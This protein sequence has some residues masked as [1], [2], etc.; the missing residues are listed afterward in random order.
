MSLRINIDVNTNPAERRLSAM[1]RRMSSFKSVFR[2]VFKELQ[3]AHRANFA[4]QGA[5]GGDIWKPLDPQYASWKLENYGARGI[6][7]RTGDLQRSLTVENA[8]GAIREIRSQSA[9]FGTSIPYA[10]FHQ[11]GTLNMPERPPIVES[12]LLNELISQK[13][14]EY[15]VEGTSVLK[16]SNTF[17]RRRF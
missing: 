1:K 9:T 2:W 14:A 16:A 4:T 10:R 6:L 7:V 3:A 15:I 12:D 11:R 5:V 8:R 17:R 13:V